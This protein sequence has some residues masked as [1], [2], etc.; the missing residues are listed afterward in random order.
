M[1]ED[2]GKEGFSENHLSI[3]QI[4][5]LRG[6]LLSQFFQ[7]FIMKNFKRA[8][9]L[10]DYYSEHLCPHHPSTVTFHST[11]FILSPSV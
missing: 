4:L 5:L 1:N 8:S 11:C 2:T 9:K 10:K 3:L 6:N 7:F